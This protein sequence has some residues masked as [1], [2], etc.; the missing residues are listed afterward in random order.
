MNKSFVLTTAE[1]KAKICHQYNAF[2]PPVASAAVRGK[3]GDLFVGFCVWSCF[4]VQY[5][6][7]HELCNYHAEEERKVI[8]LVDLL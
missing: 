1:S 4:V 3:A 6:L 8:E 2:K 5:L 7:S